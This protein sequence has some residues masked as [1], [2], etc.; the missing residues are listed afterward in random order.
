MGSA[1][2]TTR[3]CPEEHDLVD[4]GECTSCPKYRHWPEGTSEEPR[5]CWHD[6]EVRDFLAR[7]D[8][9]EDG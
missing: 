5:E 2:R 6:W 8:R 1:S 3:Y 9:E 4:L 7:K